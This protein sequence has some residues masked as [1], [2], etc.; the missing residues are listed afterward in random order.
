[1]CYFSLGEL[2]VPIK[3]ASHGVARQDYIRKARHVFY[4]PSLF[5]DHYFANSYVRCK[6]WVFM[7]EICVLV[8]SFLWQ[9]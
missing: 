4:K 2:H 8:V 1:M 3:N 9:N 6:Q 7:D 5:N